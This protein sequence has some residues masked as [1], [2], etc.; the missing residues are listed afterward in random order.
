MTEDAAA[1]VEQVDIQ[2]ARGVEASLPAAMFALQT[3][4]PAQKTDQSGSGLDQD[5]SIQVTGL[6]SATADRRGL[7]Q[8]RSRYETVILI[9]HNG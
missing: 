7:V 9:F 3:L 4:A 1:D 8:S 5:H 2:R 6:P